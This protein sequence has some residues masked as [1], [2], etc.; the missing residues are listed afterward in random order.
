MGWTQKQSAYGIVHECDVVQS[1]GKT[2]R[3]LTSMT[4]KLFIWNPNTPGTYIINGEVITIT[5]PSTAGITQWTVSQADTALL[6]VGTYNCEVQLYIANT[7]VDYT[8]TFE[9]VVQQS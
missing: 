8:D 5:S 9:L 7:L 1:D 3:D 4:A 2:A 6:P